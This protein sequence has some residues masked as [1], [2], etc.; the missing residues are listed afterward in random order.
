MFLDSFE[1]LEE[2]LELILEEQRGR[3]N[4]T[5]RRVEEEV[6]WGWRE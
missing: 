2:K 5:A 4:A 3:I 1:K 6:C